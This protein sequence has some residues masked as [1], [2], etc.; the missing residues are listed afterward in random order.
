M[1]K[2]LLLAFVLGVALIPGCYYDKVNEL[3]PAIQTGCDS[4][5]A[6]YSGNISKIINA[7]CVSCHNS[8][9]ASGNIVLDNYNDVHTQAVNG[10]LVGAVTGTGG[11]E[12][13]PPGIHLDECKIVAIEK[14]VNAGAPNN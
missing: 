1:R 2:F 5:N 12:Q 9:L 11:H 7:Y 13:M 6:S 8:S 3:H 14:W 4:T 10:F